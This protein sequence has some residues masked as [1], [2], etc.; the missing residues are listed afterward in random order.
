MRLRFLIVIIL[1]GNA[2]F[3][4]SLKNVK[5]G[6]KYSGPKIVETSIGGINGTLT[7]GSLKDGIV[8]S[9]H[10][11]SNNTINNRAEMPLFISDADNFLENVNRNFKIS[12]DC[13][14]WKHTEFSKGNWY[15]VA[16]CSKDSTSFLV[17]FTVNLKENISSIL[18]TVTNQVLSSKAAYEHLIE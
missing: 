6:E 3:S 5:I 15:D 9:F 12:L 7:I 11:V 18:L 1:L 2:V 13:K 4:Q 14:D 16:T 17:S 8:Y 10:F